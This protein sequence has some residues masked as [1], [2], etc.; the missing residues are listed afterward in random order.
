MPGSSALHQAAEPGP[1]QRP[2]YLFTPQPNDIRLA[3]R[4]A[5]AAA[6]RFRVID[7]EV[8]HR[9]GLLTMFTVRADAEQGGGSQLIRLNPAWRR[10][11]RRCPPKMLLQLEKA[12]NFQLSLSREHPVD[13]QFGDLIGAPECG[14]EEFQASPLAQ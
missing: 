3:D 13:L 11:R 2:L 6:R 1:S 9:D 14:V 10:P 7:A 12:L 4:K 8:A 5:P